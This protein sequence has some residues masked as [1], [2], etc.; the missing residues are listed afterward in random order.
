MAE[1]R[2]Y[3]CTPDRPDLA[4]FLKACVAGGVDVVQLR[5]KELEARQVLAR[6]EIALEVCRSAGVP[7]I[8]NDRP[9]LALA[10]GADGVHVGQ[11]DCPPS[12]ARRVLGPE[13][14]IG[15]S[16]H[17]PA[18]L[19]AAASEPVDYISTGPVLPTATHPDRAPTGLGYLRYAAQ[20][21]RGPWFVTG[22][23]NPATVGEMAAAGATQFV[24]VR[25]LTLAPD[26]E[27]AARAMRRAIDDALDRQLPAE[28]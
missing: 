21:C 13:A 18:E 4:D 19:D 2:L 25:H 24:V 28:P 1:R 17:A 27:A 16:T 26:P 14:V 20:H 12:V 11:D 3:L 8:L 23:A 6:A 10:V 7:F 5:D 9:D 15:L 22:N